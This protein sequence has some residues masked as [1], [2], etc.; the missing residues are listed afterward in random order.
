MRAKSSIFLQWLGL[1]IENRPHD[2]NLDT[3]TINDIRNGIYAVDTLRIHHFDQRH[4]VVLK[5][6]PPFPSERSPDSVI[7]HKNITSDTESYP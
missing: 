1:I 2:E 4:V 5:V 6:C 7:H 3:L